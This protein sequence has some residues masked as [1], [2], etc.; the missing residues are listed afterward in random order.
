MTLFM[1]LIVHRGIC[2]HEKDTKTLCA[3]VIDLTKQ[4]LTV[5]EGNTCKKKKEVYLL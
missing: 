1:A 5:Y 2:R 3:S 4:S